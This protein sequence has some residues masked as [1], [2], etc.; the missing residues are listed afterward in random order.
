MVYSSFLI[1]EL[2]QFLKIKMIILNQCFNFFFLISLQFQLKFNWKI[3]ILIIFSSFR[4]EEFF[5]NSEQVKE[6]KIL[7]VQFTQSVEIN[8]YILVFLSRYQVFDFTDCLIKYFFGFFRE[9][10]TVSWRIIQV[11]KILQI[12]WE[13]VVNEMNDQVETIF[14][15]I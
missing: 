3:L 15:F 5:N 7:I 13:I 4:F 9:F 2:V 8:F 14:F 1:I 6:K 10:V 11:A 12:N